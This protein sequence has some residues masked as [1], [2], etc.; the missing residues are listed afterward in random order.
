M[1]AVILGLVAAASF[2]A[3]FVAL[4]WA[5][6]KTGVG[7][8]QAA[9]ISVSTAALIVTTIALASGAFAGITLSSALPYV[10]S[11]LFAPGLSH[12]A[13][14]RSIDKFG[15]TRTAVVL[16]F[17]P[18]V[19]VLGAWLLLDEAPGWLVA[20]G[21]VFVVAA[22]ILIVDP[23]TAFSSGRVGASP[24]LAFVAVLC[25]A[26]RDVVVRGVDVVLAA[27]AGSA[28]SLVTA[29]ILLVGVNATSARTEIVAAVRNHLGPLL[30]PG[31]FMAVGFTS[32]I[33]GFA[34]GRVAVVS[35]MAATQS[36]WAVIMARL[37]LDRSEWDRRVVIASLLATAG[38]IVVAVGA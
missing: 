7:S 25:F 22:G 15:G 30:V 24:L 19:A 38:G 12:L 18:V 17:V 1:Q 11:G 3:V 13:M 9:V 5:Y 29:A 28:L 16:G 4:R 10:V 35:T 21:G 27:V 32:L 33:A 36:V 20:V 37:F 34:Q 31:L 6:A 26:G 14:Y 2:G 8:T 23:R